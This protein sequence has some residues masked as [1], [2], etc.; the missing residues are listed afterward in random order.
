M[1]IPFVS[2]EHKRFFYGCLEKATNY[3][4]YHQALFYIMG[5][6]E[7]TRNALPEW[8]DFSED[9]IKIECLKADWQTG[10]TQRLTRLAFNLWNDFDDGS[11]TPYDLFDCVFGKYML[12]G[13][14]LRYPEYHYTM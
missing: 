13:V 4:E 5:I 11:T 14:Q 12:V 2:D 10:S 7:I 8:F 9:S 3:D 6:S 1:N